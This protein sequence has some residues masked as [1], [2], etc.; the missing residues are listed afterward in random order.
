MVVTIDTDFNCIG[1]LSYVTG[2]LYIYAQYHVWHSCL[3]IYLNIPKHTRQQ[4][5]KQNKILKKNIRPFFF[6]QSIF[7][8]KV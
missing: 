3:K 2:F 1:N 8:S 7:V 6:F 5:I 4:S